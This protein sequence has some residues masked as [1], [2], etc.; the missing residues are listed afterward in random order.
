MTFALKTNGDISVAIEQIKK[1]WSLFKFLLFQERIMNK[2]PHV[3]Y[4]KKYF[5]SSTICKKLQVDIFKITPTGSS[6]KWAII[7][8]KNLYF[9]HN[10]KHPVFQFGQMCT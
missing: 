5:S 3:A 1:N 6:K 4:G 9:N 10:K 2:R 8:K 7:T